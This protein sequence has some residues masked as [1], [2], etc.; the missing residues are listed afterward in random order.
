[1]TKTITVRGLED[2]LH[3]RIRDQAKEHHRSMEAEARDILARGVSATGVDLSW[4]PPSGGA[5]ASGRRGEDWI[6]RARALLAPVHDDP[7]WDDDWIPDRAASPS[8]P[9]AQLG[10]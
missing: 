4:Q 2:A 10:R 5:H 9:P 6:E 7:G 3:A 1:M 8:R